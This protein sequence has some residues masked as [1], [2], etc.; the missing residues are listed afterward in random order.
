MTEEDI[1]EQAAKNNS[2]SGLALMDN[3]HTLVGSPAVISG[4]I[5]G[6]GLDIINGIDKQKIKTDLP[7]MESIDPDQSPKSSRKVVENPL[8]DLQD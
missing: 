5:A 8:D 3:M 1:V 7:K 6:K 4:M 2:P